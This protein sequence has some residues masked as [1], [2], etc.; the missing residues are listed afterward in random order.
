MTK[1]F[2]FLLLLC[3][4]ST[5][6]LAQS[7]WVTS[8][9]CSDHGATI[10]DEALEA[11][12]NVERP[13]AIAMARAAL[14]ID[15]KCG[16]AKLVLAGASG[17]SKAALFAEASSMDLSAD[18]RLWLGLM[19]S[20]DPWQPQATAILEDGNASPLF[21]WLS[22]WDTAK[23][24]VAANMEAFVESHP[25]HASAAYNMLA[26][27]Y[28]EASWGVEKADMIRAMRY[29]DL[30]E[31]THPGPNPGDSRAELLS[32]A[33]E[34]AGAFSAIRKAVDRGGSPSIYSTHAFSIWRA[35]NHEDL[36][37]AIAG[38]IQTFWSGPDVE[39]D[40][41]TRAA[42]LSETSTH[43]DSNMEDCYRATSK[44][45]VLGRM[46]GRAEWQSL[47]VSNIDVWFNADYTTAVATHMAAGQYTLDGT[48]TDYKARASTVWDLDDATGDWLLVHANFAPA[49]GAGIPSS[50]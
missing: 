38:Q 11:H 32:N 12:I 35:M 46:G 28:A 29:L 27:A 3:G 15:A 42:L 18:E 43:C 9:S 48:L 31:E 44:E 8:T 20:D 4:L 39:V 2:P 33:G 1:T 30:Y 24:T 21:A 40:Q 45:D 13:M 5:P 17:D 22:T 41:E 50:N 49:G 19:Q 47:S 36:A 25:D 10:A 23:G 37:A 14:L 26:Y 6:L 7:A 16:L 34:M